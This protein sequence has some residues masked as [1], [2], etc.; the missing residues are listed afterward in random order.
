MRNRSYL[1]PTLTSPPKGVNPSKRLHSNQKGLQHHYWGPTT[2]PK[3]N[4]QKRME[5]SAPTTIIGH[6]DKL[7]TKSDS[8][9]AN[10]VKPKN[11]HQGQNQLGQE[12]SSWQGCEWVQWVQW[13]Q[14][15]WQ[16]WSKRNGQSCQPCQL[17]NSVQT[18]KLSLS[19]KC[20][21]NS[22]GRQCG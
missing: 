14:D 7:L 10:Q 21:C 20:N 22:T 6:I 5:P 3:P 8:S 15:Q 19:K 1:F 11:P 4:G 12:P 2:S 17:D 18:C 13:R 16:Q 9:A